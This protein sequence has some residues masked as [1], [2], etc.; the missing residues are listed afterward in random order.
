M[1]EEQGLMI[2]DS[3]RGEFDFLSNFYPSVIYV[4]GERY[5]TVEHAYQAAKTNDPWS[6]RMIRNAD[7]PAKAKALGKGVPLRSDWDDVKVKVMRSLLR[8]KFENPF[9][10]PRLLETGDARLIEGNTHGDVFWGVC[11]GQGENVLGTLLEDLREEL[12]LSQYENEV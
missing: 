9:M 2:I 11:R 3:F 8:K 12:R 4:D 6:K 7:T 10:A 1:K 5:P